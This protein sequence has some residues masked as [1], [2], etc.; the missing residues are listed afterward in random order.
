MR[1]CAEAEALRRPPNPRLNRHFAEGCAIALLLS[2]AATGILD[3]LSRK[4]SLLP[5]QFLQSK[6]Q[7]THSRLL[8][9]CYSAEKEMEYLA[10]VA[11]LA[12]TGLYVMLIRLLLRRWER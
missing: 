7:S 3:L 5:Q 8:R 4:W 1:Y 11:A 10:V 6:S 2:S 12:M 9:H